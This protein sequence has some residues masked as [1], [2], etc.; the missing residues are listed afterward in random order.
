MQ[1]YDC[2]YSVIFLIFNRIKLT[3]I[4]NPAYLKCID[5]FN[6]RHPVYLEVLKYSRFCLKTKNW[7]T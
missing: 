1:Y 4:S 3:R 7:W 6:D 2:R 5:S